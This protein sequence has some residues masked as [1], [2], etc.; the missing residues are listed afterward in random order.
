MRR[1]QDSPGAPAAA[2]AP[3]MQ[4]AWRV[5]HLTLTPYSRPVVRM[6][7]EWA[8]HVTG[9]GRPGAGGVMLIMAGEP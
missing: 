3:G 4:L 8:L 9:T 6:A 7:G 5:S 2:R 1:R